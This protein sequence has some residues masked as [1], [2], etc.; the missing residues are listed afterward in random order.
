MST[1]DT[2]AISSVDIFQAGDSAVYRYYRLPSIAVSARGTV[3][4]ACEG[5]L[6]EGGDWAGSHILLRRSV[7][8]GTTWLPPQ[9]LATAAEGQT[10]KNP[11]A[12]AQKF[13]VPGAITFDNAVLIADRDGSVHLLYCVEYMRCFH[14]RSDDDGR[15]FTPAVEIT[16][17]FDTFQND[18][19]WKVLAVGPGHAIQLDNGRLVAPVW[20][21]PGT[22]AGAHHPSVAATIYSDDH[23]QTWRAGAIAIPD[24][25][26]WVDPNEGTLVQLADGR[27]LLD[28]RSESKDQRRLQTLSADG[29]E[30][31]RTLQRLERVDLS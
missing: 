19:P 2:T 9:L 25:P 4:V 17:A 21:S 12:T 5:Y 8:G 3:L 20:I 28:A 7:D 13:G 23:G 31:P 11:M 1:M 27:V 26:E 22:G 16:A 24:T 15:T 29:A 18:Y 10:E 14:M 6:T 30:Q